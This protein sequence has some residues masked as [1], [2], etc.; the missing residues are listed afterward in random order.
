MKKQRKGKERNVKIEMELITS[1]D[2][3]ELWEYFSDMINYKIA[4]ITFWEEVEE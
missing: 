4:N 3:E 1:L 2:K